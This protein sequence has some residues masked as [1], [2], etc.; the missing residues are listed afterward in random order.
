MKAV[1]TRR[2]LAVGTGAFLGAY[3][4]RVGCACAQ[5]T[6]GCFAVDPTAVL[7]RTFKQF[8]FSGPALSIV[9]KPDSG[10][11]DLDRALVFALKS[12]RTTFS[13]SPSFGFFD[14]SAFGQPNAIAT[15]HKRD[16]ESSDGNIIF[17]QNMLKDLM[18]YRDPG[19]AV[20]AVC[21]HEFGHIVSYKLNLMKELNPNETQPLRAEQYAD[22]MAGFFAGQKKLQ[23]PSYPAYDFLETLGNLAGGDHGTKEQRQEAVY[24]GY[25]DAHDQKMTMAE[26]VYRGSDWAK[27]RPAT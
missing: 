2:K 13:V 12:L 23:I 7:K 6:I 21:A 8:S 24:E 26:G 27:Q 16:G 17:G 4:L 18:R 10:D 20:L 1:M 11:S 14:D 5:Q 15:P 3:G 22:Y 19:A 25:K 9:I